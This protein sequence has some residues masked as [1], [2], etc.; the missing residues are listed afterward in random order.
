MWNSGNNWMERFPI[1][2]YW[3]SSMRILK[4]YPI[5]IFLWMPVCMF[6]SVCKCWLQ[7]VSVLTTIW[8][9]LISYN[10]SGYGYQN[11]CV[12]R[13]TCYD[14]PAVND[15]ASVS[16]SNKTRTVESR[17]LYVYVYKWVHSRRMF[18]QQGTLTWTCLKVER[19]SPFQAPQKLTT[20]ILEWN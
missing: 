11:S 12:L 14:V 3:P 9:M 19:K 16:R 8:I 13:S 6:V 10:Y 7:I 17:R 18:L 5:L 20:F 1:R 2:L 4:N 15:L